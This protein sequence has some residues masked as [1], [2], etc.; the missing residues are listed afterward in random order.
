M[1]K[2]NNN[3]GTTIIEVLVSLFLI[4]ITMVGGLQLYFNAAELNAVALHKEQ[5]TEMVN[6]RMEGYR[7]IAY[8][9]PSLALTGEDPSPMNINIGGLEIDS[10]DGRGMKETIIEEAEITATHNYKKIQ[11]DVGWNETG[12]RG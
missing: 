2:I 6:S 4:A 3:K 7:R 10:S 12:M 1:K 5:V 8:S 11:I 9:N